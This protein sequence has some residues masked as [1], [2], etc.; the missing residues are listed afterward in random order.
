MFIHRTF[1]M[2]KLI[3][4]QPVRMSTE[5]FDFFAI[6]L[7]YTTYWS[8]FYSINMIDSCVSW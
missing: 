3:I 4:A 6:Y 8:F 5:I 1:I 7:L 2:L